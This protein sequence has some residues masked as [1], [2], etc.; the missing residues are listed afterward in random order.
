MNDGAIRTYAATVAL[1]VVVCEA[2]YRVA[3]VAAC[4][5]SLDGGDRRTLALKFV[6]VLHALCVGL[7]LPLDLELHREDHAYLRKEAV[8]Q[9]ERAKC[10][11]S[12]CRTALI[13]SE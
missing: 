2:V 1:S 5:T 9:D 6:N 13:A 10:G 7:E 8:H 12:S 4:R 11:L 3:H